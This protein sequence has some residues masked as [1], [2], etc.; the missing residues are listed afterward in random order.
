M[1][2]RLVNQV[3]Q[4]TLILNYAIKPMKK[5]I[6]YITLSAQWVYTGHAITKVES[7][8]LNVI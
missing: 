2:V 5:Q 1:K 3:L 4:V 7:Y 6:R 8:R